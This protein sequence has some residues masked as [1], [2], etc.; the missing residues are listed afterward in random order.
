MFE[1]NTGV[2]CIFDL[3]TSGVNSDTDCIIDV[4][5]I[6]VR[7]EVNGDNIH[8]E[9]LQKFSQKVIPS[10]PMH[11]E[12]QKVNKY[13]PEK[14]V[15]ALDLPEVLTN[16]HWVAKGAIAVGWNIDFDLRF[17]TKAY[18]DLNWGEIPFKGYR[19]IDVGHLL[20]PYRIL[21]KMPGIDSTAQALLGRGVDHTGL[22]DCEITLDLFIEGLKRGGLKVTTSVQS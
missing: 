5:A 4:G 13:T 14:W 19:C 21:N 10:V 1:P 11:P 12:A 16:F 15:D 6:R 18:K 9:T 2:L 22:G 8:L 20:V 7:Y 17:I 3:E